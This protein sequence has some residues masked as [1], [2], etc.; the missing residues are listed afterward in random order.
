MFGRRRLPLGL[1]APVSLLV[2]VVAL[3]ALQYRW[4][5]QVS[6]AE[7]EQLKQS[8][9]R[10]AGE[11]ADDFDREIG[12]AY[13]TFRLA[14]GFT[15]TAPERF[16]QQYDEWLGAARFPGMLKAA[17]LA[18]QDGNRLALH[19]YSPTARAFEAADWPSSLKKVHERLTLTL[20]HQMSS[21]TGL[22]T[23]SGAASIMITTLP[24]LPEVPA[25]VI[26][27]A[28]A[29]L[30]DGATADALHMP[31]V[32]T[33]FTVALKV[34]RNYIVLEL[35]R[36]F[37]SSTVL[38]TLIER[39]FPESDADRFRISV[40]DGASKVLLSRGI[41]AGQ[42]LSLTRADAA[43]G[44][45]GIRI[46]TVR[47]VVTPMR[48][49]GAAQSTFAFSKRSGG[50]GAGAGEVPRAS[51][52][53]ASA[54]VLAKPNADNADRL[55]MVIEQH[56]A[57]VAGAAA[58]TPSSAGWT[59]LLQHGAGSLDAAVDR[60]RRRNLWLSFGILSVLAA[61]AGLVMIN[62][63]RSERLAA[64]QMDFVATVSHELRTPVAVIRSAA[65]NLS[66]GVIH[67][68]DQARR[69]G[70]LIE[71]EG[72][73]LTDMVEQVLEYAGLSD[74]R[75]APASR[76]VDAGRLVRDV[77]AAS[78]SLPE[79]D[80]LHFEVRIDDQAPAVMADED[81][82]RRALLNLVGNAMKYGGDGGWIGVTVARGSGRDEG[83]VLISVA[84]RGRGIPAEELAHI[85]EPFYRGAYARDRQI[86]GN[87]LGLSL[88][89]RI[90][91]AHGGRVT[92]KSAPDQGST[93]TM[94]LPV[95][96]H[97]VAATPARV[98]TG[99]QSA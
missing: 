89:Q 57:T 2:L 72:R 1:L 78:E 68:P 44:F 20:P 86:H 34:P 25:L 87:G 75:R 8:L 76:P 45:F 67:E 46:E 73:R 41:A 30:P 54:F 5:G 15:T 91:T 95:A 9:D 40:V 92:V 83:Q 11:F 65:Q 14:P 71:A 69:Y 58:R 3:G 21:L 36:D 31:G 94:H 27:E 49:G 17:Y 81:A 12:R 79:A 37:I 42:M 55:S 24:V 77:V 18:A 38:P 39:H 43:M 50:D 84:D 63:R 29:T 61:S 62:A 28:Q 90:V 23:A 99:G 6:E 19:R 13:Q 56:S 88:V 32:A 33:A 80:G 22:G 59:L 4:V 16:A 85:F 74:H 96:A 35:D 82:V 51:G 93:F 53:S 70:E 60:A 47:G 98:A 7:R 26:A 48:S 66:A 10:R 52:R 97:V 64:Q